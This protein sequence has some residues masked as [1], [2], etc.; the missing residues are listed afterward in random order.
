MR[1]FQ[2]ILPLALV[3]S[4]ALA[5]PQPAPPPGQ[6]NVPP[7]LTDPATADRISGMMHALSKAFVNLPVG[8]IE[9]A[10]EGRPATQADRRRTI[11]DLGRKHDPDFDRNLDR[12]IEASRG[13][14][15]ASMKAFTSAL[16]AVTRSITEARRAIEQATA[17]LPSPLYPKR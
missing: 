11:G 3:A 4:P 17:N 10:A 14:V 8:E 5:Q 15:Q 2:L 1:A 16:P 7:E 12:D 13:A 6:I 9:A